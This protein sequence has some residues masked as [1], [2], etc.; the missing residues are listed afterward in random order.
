MSNAFG[1]LSTALSA[2]TAQRRGL[3]LAGQNIANANTEGYSRQRVDLRSVGGGEVPAMYSTRQATG[4]GVAVAD[5]VRLRDAFLDARDRTERADN[6]YLIDE[7]QVYSQVERLLTEPSETGL[8]AQLADVW[9]AWHDVANNPGDL[10]ARSQ[11]LQQAATV[12]GTLNQSHAGLGALW[13]ANRDQLDAL[14]ADVNSTAGSVAELN[15]KIVLATAAGLPANELTDRRDQL[16]LR[17]ADL[18]GASVLRQPNGSADVLLAGAAL[19][20]GTHTRKLEAAG[21]GGLDNQT[22]NPVRLRWADNAAPA[23]V[24]TG[25]IGSVLA[26]L[27]GTVPHYAAELDAVAASLASTVNAGHAG[28]YDLAGVAGGTFF[29]GSTAATIAVAITNPAKVAA[30]GTPG[31]N[32]GGGNADKLAALATVAGGADL[33]YRQV[34]ADLGA[35]AHT[36]NQRAAIQAALTDQADAAVAAHSGVSLDEE[37]T[38]MLTYQRAYEAAAR[39]MSTVDSLLDTLINIRR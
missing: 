21:A 3:E 12:A 29:T 33:R 28:G 30:S 5:V 27:G 31:G 16:V 2:L 26:T 17:L 39:L 1:G 20:S 4:G 34:V 24:Q 18:T 15:Q 38:N 11:L 6:A 23:T 22:A 32:L 10:A 13:S 19:V 8:Q 25:Q 14:V 37:M 36:V 35:V 9:A 7:Q